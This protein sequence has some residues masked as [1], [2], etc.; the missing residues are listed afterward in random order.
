MD[1]NKQVYKLSWETL[2]QDWP[3]WIFL[4]GLLALSIML[5]PHLPAKVPVHW[6]IH[7]QI[8]RYT[9]KQ[10]GTFMML[11]VT[12]G[13]YLM[14]LLLPLIDPKRENYARFAG[15]YR[16]FRWVFVI[17][18]GSMHVAI[19]MVALGYHLDISIL[20]K[21]GVSILFLVIG[22]FM[23]QIR[24]NYFVGVKTPWTLSNE[25]V[26]QQTHR[27]AAKIWV[28]CS[29][30]CLAMSPFQAVWSAWIFFA[31]VAVMAIGPIAYSYVAYR[32]VVG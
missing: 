12:A 20:V 23:G 21:A 19:L 28:I 7:G 32:R 24:Y 30:V 29:L 22:N 2:K 14:F 10:I 4:A 15:A 3:I 9:T 27:F 18:M 17:F 13:M 8:D 16:L 31:S 6:N 26:W 25:D 1:E 11:G 5:Y